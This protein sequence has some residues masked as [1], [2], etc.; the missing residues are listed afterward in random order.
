MMTTKQLYKLA[1]RQARV[2]FYNHSGW[3]NYGE[4]VPYWIFTLADQHRLN[5]YK[6]DSIGVFYR[7]SLQAKVQRK[8][9]IEKLA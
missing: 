4:P 7:D 6:Q 1:Y 2:G 8:S 3:S 9:L 5:S